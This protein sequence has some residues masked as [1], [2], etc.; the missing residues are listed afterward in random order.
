MPIEKFETHEAAARALWC[1]APD[2]AYYRKVAAHFK[3]G[4]RLYGIVSARG[5]HKYR[6]ISDIRRQAA[7]KAV[8]HTK[9]G[10][11]PEY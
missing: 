11:G 7:V 3:L 4:Q 10:T 9:H 1:Y 2:S 5:V 6:G 8:S